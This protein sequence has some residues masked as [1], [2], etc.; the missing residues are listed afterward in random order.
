MMK[1]KRIIKY[2]II[3]SILILSL[4]GC[5]NREVEEVSGRED[6][7]YQFLVSQMIQQDGGIKS[8]YVQRSYELEWARGNE[9]LS[10]SQGLG[11][12]YFLE[13]RDQEN[14]DKL[15]DFVKKVMNQKEGLSY[16]YTPNTVQAWNINALIDDLRIIDALL[17]GGEVF[18]SKKYTHLA[19][20]WSNRLY[21]TNVRDNKLYDFY[22]WELQMGNEFIT[23]CY[24]DLNT[25]SKLSEYDLRWKDVKE[26]A[27]KIVKKGYIGD[28]FPMFKTR[29]NYTTNQYE[30][31]E[32]INMV[33]ASLT[34]LHLVEA[35]YDAKEAVNF[36]RERVAQGN[37][38]THYSLDGEPVTDI[39]S[40]AI[41][42][43]CAM[44]ASEIGDKEFYEE[45]ITQMSKWQVLNSE[46]E[47]YGA[48]GNES[49][50]EVYSFD[51]L[52][53]LLAYRK[54]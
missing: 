33:E 50:L 53:A 31:G 36:L 54:E 19:K 10:E 23:L 42:A 11:M 16:R 39:Q 29:Y 8:N 21:E 25:L 41:Y 34:V 46:S 47:I 9:V 40:T 49:N 30:V 14:Y 22:D 28:H 6:L 38:Y 35:D 12:Q 1:T 7:C 26:E 27:G 5:T 4:S 18:E 45:S 43:I 3:C 44:I 32:S 2:I 24:I 15:L 37:L 17:E 13:I 52:M 20:K 51:N 48:F